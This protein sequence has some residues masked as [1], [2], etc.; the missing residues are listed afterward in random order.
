MSMPISTALFDKIRVRADAVIVPPEMP[1]QD[2][3]RPM[4]R[5]GFGV[6][7]LAAADRRLVGVLTDGD[8]RR[9][10]LRRQPLT[11]PCISIATREPIKATLEQDLS[12]AMYLMERKR[13]VEHLPLVDRDDRIV[14]LLLR[15]DL[16][17]DELLAISAV[18]MAGGFGTRL[19]P[20]TADTPKPLLPVGGRPIMARLVDELRLS[21]IRRVTVTT[22]HQSEKIEGYFG[23]GAAFGMNLS[24]V[25]EDEPLGTAGALS[26]MEQQEDPLLVVNADI[27]T[28]VNFRAMVQFHREHGADLTVGVRE[29]N[30]TIPYGVVECDGVRVRALQE[31]P[32]S[33]YLINAGLYLLEP[34]VRQLIPSGTRFDMTDLI[35]RLLADGRAV[36]SFPITEYWLDIGRHA[37]YEQAQDDVRNGRLTK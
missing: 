23:D 4:D 33:S 37:D 28:N 12:D 10:I 25:S 11:D 32:V 29:W 6:L 30:H 9:A 35:Q 2:A 21:G 27:L 16:V 31:K 13:G 17:D 34:N 8:I 24:Y 5:A 7:F 22:H 20:L 15:S 3:L 14:G 26:L 19:H 1:I 18:V 36:V